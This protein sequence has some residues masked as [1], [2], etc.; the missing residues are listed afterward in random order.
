PHAVI[1][2]QYITAPARMSTPSARTELT[3]GGMV[4]RRDEEHKFARR[5][6]QVAR[7]TR[8]QRGPGPDAGDDGALFRSMRDADRRAAAALCAASHARQ[9]QLPPLRSR[10]PQELLPQG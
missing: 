1:E 9:H 8:R 5:R 10:R 7:S 6:A 3:F 2:N 4:R